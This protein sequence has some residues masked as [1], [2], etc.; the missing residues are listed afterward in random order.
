MTV[1]LRK[2]KAGEIPIRVVD[3]A[4]HPAQL[5]QAGERERRWLTAV[6]FNGA[7]DSQ[8][9]PSHLTGQGFFLLRARA[10]MY[11]IMDILTK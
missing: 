4:S 10:Q 6:G 7:P 11:E 5:A 8:V 2:A 1:H 3:R 9:M